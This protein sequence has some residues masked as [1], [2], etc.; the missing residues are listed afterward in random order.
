MPSVHSNGWH[1]GVCV[2]ATIMDGTLRVSSIEYLNLASMTFA[3]RS[4]SLLVGGASDEG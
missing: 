1:H 2:S 3:M 4:R